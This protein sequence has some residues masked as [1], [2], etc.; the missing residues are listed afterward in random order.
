MGTKSTPQTTD[1]P[2]HLRGGFCFS[3]WWGE[4]REGFGVLWIFQVNPFLGRC[5]HPS[6]VVLTTYHLNSCESAW[7]TGTETPY[8]VYMV[9]NPVEGY[10]TSAISSCSWE[11]LNEWTPDGWIYLVPVTP[12]LPCLL[13][14]SETLSAG[15]SVLIL[16]LF[17]FSFIQQ[18]PKPGALDSSRGVRSRSRLKFLSLR[19]FSRN[20][21]DVICIYR[22]V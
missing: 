22:L 7:C 8:G 3:F 20:E 5:G 21:T 15:T 13:C 4:K 1:L 14:S 19:P 17:L 9:K 18:D 6:L 11:R 16:F 12:H 10:S 2:A